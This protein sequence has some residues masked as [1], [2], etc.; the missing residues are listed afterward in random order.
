MVYAKCNTSFS[1]QE[2][3]I[4]TKKCQTQKDLEYKFIQCTPKDILNTHMNICS[5]DKMAT[6]EICEKKFKSASSLKK[7]MYTHASYSRYTQGSYSS[8][9][10][11][12]IKE[13]P[14]DSQCKYSSV[15]E[16]SLEMHIYV[17]KK[18]IDMGTSVSH[19]KQEFYKCDKCE[20]STSISGEFKLHIVVNHYF[21]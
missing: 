2:I 10:L 8:A 19:G 21:A 18:T 6:C 12:Q 16:E 9:S 11:S 13:K 17:P 4:H 20:Y 7:H 15:K 14:K 3:D 5:A 1:P